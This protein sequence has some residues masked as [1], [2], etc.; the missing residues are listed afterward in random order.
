MNKETEFTHGLQ[1]LVQLAKAQGNQVSEE[2]LQETFENLHLEAAQLQLVY[3][4]L[5]EHKI[6][7][8]ETV[9]TD[10]YLTGE[11]IEYLELYLEELKL[12]QQVNEKEQEEI[13]LHVMQ[14]EETAA[15]KLIECYLIKVVE[16]A[17]LYAGQGVEI[18]DLIGEGNVAL[19]LG[20]K[21]LTCAESVNE[22]EGMLA[23][24]MMDTMERCIRENLACSEADKQILDKI[25]EIS[26]KAQELAES[27]GRKITVKEMI[28]ETDYTEDEIREAI[29]VTANHLDYIEDKADADE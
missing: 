23:K 21:M 20:V 8:G 5:K 17:K 12:L 16:I 25:N 24:L 18:E 29:R 13:I 22:A 6:G 28:R 3:A 15:A 7:V 9:N 2:Q 11:D 26:T 10:D 1:Q 19:T 14:G 4:Y 27:I